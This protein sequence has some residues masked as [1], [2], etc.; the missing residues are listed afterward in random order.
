MG[1]CG[2][3]VSMLVCEVVCGGVSWS[4]LAGIAPA[5]TPADEK[6]GGSSYYSN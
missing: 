2:Q 3:M 1:S 6:T 5:V 4:A